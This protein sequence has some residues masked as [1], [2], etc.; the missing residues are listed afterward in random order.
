MR[1]DR[2]DPAH[3]QGHPAG[4]LN[5]DRPLSTVVSSQP[6][7]VQVWP[8]TVSAGQVTAAPVPVQRAS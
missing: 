7:R 4:S 8:V 6:V 2:I 5:F 3:G 1:L